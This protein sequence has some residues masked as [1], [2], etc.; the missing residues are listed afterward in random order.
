MRDDGRGRLGAVP[1]VQSNHD[2]GPGTNLVTAPAP[3][4]SP[5][6]L[7]ATFE[8]SLLEEAQ[9]KKHCTTREAV[10]AG[11]AAG[12]FRTLLTHFSQRYPKIPVVDANFQVRWGCWCGLH[13]R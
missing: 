10:E 2:D 5:S 3:P 13:C 9:A 7:Q 6:S 1:W 11:A 12:A 4:S 8:D